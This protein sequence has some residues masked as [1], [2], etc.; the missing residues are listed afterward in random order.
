M[1]NH[2][3]DKPHACVV[4]GMTFSHINSLAAHRLI[5]SED[6]PFEWDLCD[7][8]FSEP[9]ELENHQ[10]THFEKPLK[11]YQCDHI[12]VS[13]KNLRVHLKLNIT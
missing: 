9:D 1:R 2:A 8:K 5:H 3:R 7:Q 10:K 13:S 11:C 6:K 12:F 4:C